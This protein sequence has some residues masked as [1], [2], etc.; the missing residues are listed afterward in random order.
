MG[1]LCFV[2]RK[3]GGCDEG[4][5]TPQ[6]ELK[7]LAERIEGKRR[8]RAEAMEEE[9]E[10]QKV[11]MAKRAR[12]SQVIPTEGSP[13]SGGANRGQGGGGEGIG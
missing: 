2:I 3:P 13:V 9:E 5:W 4:V 1:T 12:A 11:V 7:E 8:E 10:L 6:N